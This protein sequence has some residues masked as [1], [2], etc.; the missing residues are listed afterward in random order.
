MT[1]KHLLGFGFCVL[2]IV[3][4]F[5]TAL[6]GYRGLFRREVSK[7]WRRIVAWLAK[8]LT[9]SGER[10]M[11]GSHDPYEAVLEEEIR[12]AMDESLIDPEDVRCLE[13]AGASPPQ[14]RLAILAGTVWAV[15][16]VL[17]TALLVF[18]LFAL[19]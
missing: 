10:A 9:T 17:S 4:I 11:W 16:S 8:L 3:W 1:L 6:Q 12:E 19:V 13:K 14:V 7:S 5:Y 15:V 18:V 2:L